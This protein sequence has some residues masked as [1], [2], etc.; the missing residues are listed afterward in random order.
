MD[1]QI[2]FPN[3]H[4]WLDHVGKNISIFGFSIAYYG[5]C[6]AIAMLAGLAAARRYA[7]ISGQDPELYLD[8]SLYLMVFGILGARIYYVI[9][10]WKDYQ[11]NL[12]SIFNL[13][14]GGLAVYG[15][16]LAGVLT[17]FLYAGRKKENAFQM[18]DTV[19]FGLLIGQVIGRWGNFFNREVFGGYTNGLLAMRLPVSAVRARDITKELSEH[20]ITADGIEYIQVH[21]T[22]LY[23]GIWNLCLFFLLWKFK[24]HKKYEGQL[25]LI[26]LLGYGV[27]RFWIEG[28]RTD[29]LMLTEHIAVSQLLALICVIASSGM[30]VFMK[31]KNKKM[32]DA[33][34][35]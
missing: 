33:N 6:I 28:I 34:E 21:P 24:E 17:I 15:G 27:G 12:L 14:Q 8:L 19:G 16:I 23:E 18:L 35:K 1:Y 26:Y 9:F 29:Q 25:F 3:L 30:L 13:R 11:G 31:Q 4:I 32:E 5:I 22:F 2:S 7:K 10:R 20:L